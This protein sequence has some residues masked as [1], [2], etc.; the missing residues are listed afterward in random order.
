MNEENA[1]QSGQDWGT[2]TRG[3]EALLSW[4]HQGATTAPMPWGVTGREST[5]IRIGLGM[6]GRG[7][8]LCDRAVA[9]SGGHCLCHHSGLM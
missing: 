7:V 9:L 8:A 6:G 4:Q 1:D 5:V 3:R 2:P